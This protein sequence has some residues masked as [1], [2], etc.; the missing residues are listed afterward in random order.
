MD[1]FEELSWRGLVYDTTEGLREAIR[2]APLTGYI[3]FDPTAASLHVGSLLPVMA[4][5]RLQRCGHAPIALVGGG[6]GL[7][8][9]PSGK[10]AERTLLTIGAGRGERGRHSR[11]ARTLPRFRC[12]ETSR[13]AREQRRVAGATERHGVPA[14]RRQVLHRQRHARQGIGEAA[15]RERGRHLVHRVQLLAAA[16]LRLPRAAR[17]IRLHAADRAA[18]ISGAT[19]PPASI[20]IRR[21]R[22]AKTHGLVHAASHHRRRARSSARPKAARCGWTRRSRPRTS[23]ISSGSTPTIAMRGA[24]SSSSP[25]SS[26]ARCRSSRRRARANR[27]SGMRSARWRRKSLASCTDRPR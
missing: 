1:L 2:A 12:A 26:R 8:G 7:I 19:S 20:S 14:R 15:D 16:G 10:S 22:G 27:K 23:S 5:A 4:L 3:G 25:S 11:A 24:I 13:A 6:T 17:A 21:V 18:A 9:D